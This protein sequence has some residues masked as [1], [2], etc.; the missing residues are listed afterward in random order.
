MLTSLASTAGL[1]AGGTIFID[2]PPEQDYTL[3]AGPSLWMFQAYPGGKKTDTL[4][5]PGVDLYFANGVFVSTDNGIGWNLSRR[6]DLQFGPRLWAQLKRKASAS[7]RLAGTADIGARLEKGAFLNYAPYE[8]LLVQSSVRYG[9]GVRG[10]GLLG[11]V[12]LTA[13]APLGAHGT[14]ALTLGSTWANQAYRQSYFGLDEGAAQRSNR[15]PWQMQSGLQDT[16][17]AISGEYHLD[18]DWRLSGQWIRARL[19]GDAARSPVTESATQN[20]LSL[21]LWRRFK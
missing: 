6:D 21:T 15:S 4:L 12:G 11:E 7:P 3:S 13:G 10:D 17:L 1:A 2:R 20:L 5:L 19:Q 14:L 18:A 16:S 8:F 9:S